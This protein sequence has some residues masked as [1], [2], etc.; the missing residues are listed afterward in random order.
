MERSLSLS[1]ASVRGPQGDLG[2]NHPSAGGSPGRPTHGHNA[3][4]ANANR[5][6]RASTVNLVKPVPP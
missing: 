4:F 5:T 2:R 6:V 3:T 1:L